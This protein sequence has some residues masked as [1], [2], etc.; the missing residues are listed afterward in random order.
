MPLH[1]WTGKISHVDLTEPRQS[2]LAIQPHA[3]NTRNRTQPLSAVK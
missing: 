1:G 3:V 2:Y